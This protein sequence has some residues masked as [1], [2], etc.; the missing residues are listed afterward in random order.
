MFLILLYTGIRVGELVTPKW[1]D[2]DFKNHTISLT[3]PYYHPTNNTV[4]DRLFHSPYPS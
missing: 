1:K 4:E 2:V 3:K